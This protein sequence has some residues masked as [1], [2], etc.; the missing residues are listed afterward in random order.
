MKDKMK[1]FIG[2]SK[3][4]TKGGQNSLLQQIAVIVAQA[5]FTPV[6]WNKTPTIFQTGRTIIE[7]LESL[8]TRENIDASIFIF[9]EKDKSWERENNVN[10]PRSNVLFE[11]GLFTAKLGRTKSIIIKDGN[12]EIPSDLLG[13]TY[14]DF[15]DATA[16]ESNI[17]QWLEE[18]TNENP[19]TTTP[20]K[21]HFCEYHEEREN[22]KQ[23]LTKLQTSGLV[24]VFDNQQ[25]AMKDY[26]DIGEKSDLPIRI[27]CIRGDSFASDKPGNWSTVL[28][29]KS[30]IIAIFSS[31]TNTDLIKSRYK[32]CHR[33]N[34]TETLFVKR[35]KREMQSAQ[36]TIKDDENNQLYLHTENDFSYRMLFVDDILYMSTFQADTK[37]SLLK[38]IKIQKDSDL[39][40]ICEDYFNKIKSNAIKQ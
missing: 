18:L 12:V 29:G 31:T 1:I 39:Y 9:S 21:P 38:V 17:Q 27:L 23:K 33:D 14:I 32:S 8:I 10:V 36:D 11:L 4:A 28:N 24:E 35:Y 13:V 30:P 19:K 2:S 20:I 15:N 7:N 16:A 5:G 25:D 6:K 37:A 34:E 22:I 40:S 26:E 3:D